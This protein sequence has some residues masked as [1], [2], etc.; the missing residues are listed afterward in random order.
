MM[1]RFSAT[2][3]KEDT[4]EFII[5]D[6]PGMGWLASFDSAPYQRF[7]VLIDREVKK[8]W[9]PALQKQLE[10]HNKPISY[11][12]V[13]AAERSKSLSFY[14]EVV[15]FLESHTCNLGDMVIA[16]GGG[17][18]MDLAGFTCSTYMR[19]LRFIAVPTTLI[20]QM[21][22]VTAGKTCLNT[23]RSKNLLGTFYYPKSVYNNIHF[24]KTNKTRYLRQGYSEIF[25]YGLLGSAKLIERLKA[26]IKRP[27]DKGWMELI[28]LASEVRIRIRKEDPLASNLGHT[29]GHA[30]ERL[31]DFK[32]LHGDAIS[33][34]TVM[35]LYF[36]EKEGLIEETAVKKIVGDM[37]EIG[38]NLYIDEKVEAQVLAGAMAKD[39]KATARDVNLV[40]VRGVEKPYEKGGFH[41]YKTTSAS[42]K[43]FL[44][45]FLKRYPYKKEGCAQFLKKDHLEYKETT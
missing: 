2:F 22:A 5:D 20:G 12:E 4:V 43:S 9:G 33:A 42:I 28:R 16:V 39:K 1:E 29:F 32:M 11:F 6:D 41:F 26:H 27:S 19:A 36:A 18:V 44:E 3:K 21:D 30:L 38:L 31:S 34:G 23:D 7:F 15:R 24:L 45:D 17:I 10:R 14:P 37:Q 13:E 8:K 25:K 35:A 40:L